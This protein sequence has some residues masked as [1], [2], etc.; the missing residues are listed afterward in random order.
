M[1]NNFLKEKMLTTSHPMEF[2]IDITHDNVF[3]ICHATKIIIHC[4]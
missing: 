1:D 3:T 4:V 2:K